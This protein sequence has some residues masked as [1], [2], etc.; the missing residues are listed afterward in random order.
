MNA[1]IPH[2]ATHSSLDIFEKLSVLVNF[3]SG[4]VQEFFPITSSNSPNLEFEFASD[5]NVYIDL[6]NIYLKLVVKILKGRDAILEYGG[7]TDDEV[8]FPNN[9]QH[10]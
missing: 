10:S 4:N 3:D 9:T 7:A 2:A 6:Q 5:R 8:Q 1:D